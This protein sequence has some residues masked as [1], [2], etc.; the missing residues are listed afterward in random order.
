MPLPELDGKS[1]ITK[2]GFRGIGKNKTYEYA[3]ADISMI[4]YL[5][6]KSDVQNMHIASSKS[7]VQNNQK[8]CSNHVKSDVQIVPTSN[9]KENK[10]ISKIRGSIEM[11]NLD[12]DPDFRKVMIDAGFEADLDP[13]DPNYVE[14]EE[15]VDSHDRDS[16]EPLRTTFAPSRLS[17]ASARKE[18]SF[19][20][21]YFDASNDRDSDHD[22][23]D[24]S[25]RDSV[26]HN[27]TDMGAAGD[28]LATDGTPDFDPV[29]DDRD[30]TVDDIKEW[31][32]LNGSPWD[33]F[34]LPI[35][36]VVR[37]NFP[38]STKFKSVGVVKSCDR[39]DIVFKYTIEFADESRNIDGCFLD[40]ADKGSDQNQTGSSCPLDGR[41]RPPQAI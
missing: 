16:N 25:D 14:S 32:R 35:E 18:L 28:P 8:R 24:S 41:S 29:A 2:I 15:P 19:N 10:I 38:K 5:Y 31:I 20:S 33:N 27:S 22:H 30:S 34:R 17:S 12:Q 26:D 4:N 9:T 13:I 3:F 39:Y 40:V 7:D 21:D 36:T 37:V 23:H 1:V 6:T 11:K